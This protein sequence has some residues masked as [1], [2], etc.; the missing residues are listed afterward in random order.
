[1][2][3]DTKV[4]INEEIIELIEKKVAE[5]VKDGDLTYEKLWKDPEKAK[6]EGNMSD[7]YKRIYEEL[8]DEVV[9]T[10]V[11]ECWKKGGERVSEEEFQETMKKTIKEFE[12]RMRIESQTGIKRYMKEECDTY[13]EGELSRFRDNVRRM[14]EKMFTGGEVTLT[15]I[16]GYLRKC[17]RV[18]NVIKSL[19]KDEKITVEDQNKI[20]RKTENGKT[21]IYKN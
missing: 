17:G 14:T 18:E 10:M 1:M 15:E 21:T 20:L 9:E 13:G 19:R 6:D 5:T 4:G 3:K 16:G 2:K 8:S 7:G 12:K 11:E